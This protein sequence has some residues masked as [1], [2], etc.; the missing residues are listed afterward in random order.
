MW[1]LHY[2]KNTSNDIRRIYLIQIDNTAESHKSI[3]YTKVK[4]NRLKNETSGLLRWSIQII[5]T[6]I[7]HSKVEMTAVF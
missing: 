6:W 4:K 1:I 3:K 2:L 7:I 5:N